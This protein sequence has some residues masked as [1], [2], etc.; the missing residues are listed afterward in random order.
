MDRKSARRP[1]DDLRP[2]RDLFGIVLDGCKHVDIP[3][4]R[5]QSASVTVQPLEMFHFDTIPGP[6]SE[7]ASFGLARY[8]AEIEVTY[9]PT[10]RRPL[11]RD[12]EEG[13]LYLV[14]V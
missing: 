4:H 6:G 9:C 13:R 11:H 3:W 1:L 7:W 10:V 14:A 2:K 12:G 8:P 5:K